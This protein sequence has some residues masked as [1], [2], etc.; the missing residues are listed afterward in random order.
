MSLVPGSM[1][2]VRVQVKVLPPEADVQLQP[3]DVNEE[4]FTVTPVGSVPVTV[5][6]DP[7][8]T[9]L[10]VLVTSMAML[11]AESPCINV[12]GVLR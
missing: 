7:R 8:V 12:E 11:S 5:T 4:V 10:L 3:P 9:E 2:V 1:V 6:S